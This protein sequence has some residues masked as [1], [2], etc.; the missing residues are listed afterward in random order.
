MNA[1]VVC[2]TTT[3]NGFLEWSINN[4]PPVYS[5]TNTASV[6]AGITIDGSVFVFSSRTT[7]SGA[8]VYTSTA[9]L[10][11]SHVTSVQCSDGAGA[12]SRSIQFQGKYNIIVIVHYYTLFSS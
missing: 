10:N 1:T 11:T 4:G 6:N 8:N 2:T 9:S 3:L 7:V 5:I 12:P